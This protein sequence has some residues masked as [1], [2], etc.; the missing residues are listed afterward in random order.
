MSI[1]ELLDE[2]EEELQRQI[3]DRQRAHGIELENLQRHPV[4]IMSYYSVSRIDEL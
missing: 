3:A 1:Q 4:Y 2:N